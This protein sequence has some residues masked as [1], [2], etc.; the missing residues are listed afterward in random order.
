MPS[1]EVQTQ[2]VFDYRRGLP[3]LCEGEQRLLGLGLEVGDDDLGAS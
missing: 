1:R 3:R 2:E